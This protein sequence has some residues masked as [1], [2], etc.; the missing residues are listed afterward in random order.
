MNE[1]NIVKLA[2]QNRLSTDRC[3]R[4]FHSKFLVFHTIKMTTISN[5]KKV[6]DQVFIDPQVKCL[7]RLNVYRMSRYEL[8]NIFFDSG[9]I[10]VDVDAGL[11]SKGR[12]QVAGFIT[13]FVVRLVLR[14]V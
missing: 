1:F 4:V 10:S 5:L 11:I 12:D 2:N 8:F 13:C 7:T 9:R 3:G 6:T 14:R